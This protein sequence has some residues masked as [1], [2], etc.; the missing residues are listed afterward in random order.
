MNNVNEESRLVRVRS[1]QHVA[2]DINSYELVPADGRPLPPFTAGSHIDVQVPNG[3][4]RQYSLHG[5][6]EDRSA[7][8]IAI[9][10]E[11]DGR[12]GSVSLHKGVEEGSTLGIVGP[13]NFFPLDLEAKHHV[14]IAGGIG[15]TPLYAMAQ[16]LSEG[17][18]GWTLHYCARSSEHAAFYDEFQRLNNG[19]VISH[20]SEL[21]SLNVT[22]LLRVQEPGTH[23]YCCGPEGLMKAVEAAGAHWTPGHLHFEWF[24]AP[25]VSWPD[26]E[27]I[28]IELARS[29]RTLHVPVDRTIL[30]VL[31][32][33]DISVMCACEEGVCGTCETTV[34]EGKPQ[35][36]DMLL[37]PEE[38]EESRSMMVCVSRAVS[39]RL[40]LDL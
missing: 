36:R 16:A 26:N 11:A 7:Y 22:D 1:I 5:N 30:Q 34:L 3:M 25:Q 10:R 18:Q 32:E 8:H 2:R 14:L 9:K 35:H 37:T 31:R 20:F 38:R 40:V 17:A 4:L 15:V 23:V 39:P 28:E 6:P 24:S 19:K 21:P 29:G 13:R 33:N 12:G 27:P